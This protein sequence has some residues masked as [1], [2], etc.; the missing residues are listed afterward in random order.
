MVTEVAPAWENE[1]TATSTESFHAIL[2]Q[3]SKNAWADGGTRE[4]DIC[5]PALAATITRDAERLCSQQV[6]F[7]AQLFI[8]YFSGIAPFE[9]LLEIQTI[10]CTCCNCIGQLD[11]VP[12]LSIVCTTCCV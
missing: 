11:E 12:W 3:R 10:A 9:V 6:K 4:L 7:R 2:E 1:R 5:Q 8:L